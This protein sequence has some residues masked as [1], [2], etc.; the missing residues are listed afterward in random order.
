MGKL[1]RAILRAEKFARED[2]PRTVDAI[3]KYLKLDRAL[4]EKAYYSGYL[5]QTTDPNAHGVQKFWKIMQAS[6]FVDSKDSIDS[7][8]EVAIYKDALD[9]LARESP[10]DPYWPELEKKFAARNL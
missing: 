3:A 5:D 10:K 8:I 1:V 4:I 2:H 9:G 7:H 6:E